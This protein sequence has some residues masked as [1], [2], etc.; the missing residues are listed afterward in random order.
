MTEK[1]ERWSIAEV[2]ILKRHYPNM[3]R[4]DLMQLLPGRTWKA[5]TGAAHRYGF[6]RNGD[7]TQ[8]PEQKAAMLAHLDIAR[9]LRTGPPFAG[10]HHSADAKLAIS[11]SNLHARGHSIAA[12]AKR[13]G[14]AEA[15]VKKMI[16]ERGTKYECKLRDLSEMGKVPFDVLVVVQKEE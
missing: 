6:S 1:W 5:I 2:A 3:P 11:V 9:G 15:E 4:A 16:E 7:I 10:K 12:I 13:N 8:T 14:I